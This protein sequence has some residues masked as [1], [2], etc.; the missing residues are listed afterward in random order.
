PLVLPPSAFTFGDF[1]LRSFASFGCLSSFVFGARSA[2][3]FGDFCLRSLKGLSCFLPPSESSF[4]QNGTFAASS[5]RGGRSAAA[6]GGWTSTDGVGT[7]TIAVGASS[8][9]S[10]FLLPNESSFFQNGTFAASSASGGRSASATGGW[11]STDGDCTGRIAVEASAIGAG[12]DDGGAFHGSASASTLARVSAATGSSAT[13][14][15]TV[16]GSA[17]SASSA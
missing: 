14:S 17:A 4:F 8:G 7:G 3:T 10:R 16:L 13:S 1:C 15:S 5:A 11:T 12:G 2:F 6:T 9:L